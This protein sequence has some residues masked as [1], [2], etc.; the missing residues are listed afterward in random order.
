MYVAGVGITFC[1][2][3][4][5]HSRLLNLV[6]VHN[7]CLTEESPGGEHPYGRDRIHFDKRPSRPA[8]LDDVRP[9]QI[10]KATSFHTRAYESET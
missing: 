5:H 7:E 2:L 8:Q 9:Q 3:T 6:R 1:G 4:A 10:R